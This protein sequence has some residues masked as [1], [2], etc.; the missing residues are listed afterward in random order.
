MKKTS[1]GVIVFF[2]VLIIL[3]ILFFMWVGL[4]SNAAILSYV[5]TTLAYFLCGALLLPRKDGNPVW[6]WTLNIISIAFFVVEFIASI[7]LGCLTDSI[8]IVGT[9]HLLIILGFILWAAPH[10]ASYFNSR[11]M[12]EQQEKNAAYVKNLSDKLRGIMLHIEDKETRKVV[13]KLT[14]TIWCSPRATNKEAQVKEAAV[15]E[16]VAEIEKGVA[17]ADWALV[18]S[19]A[20]SAI[21]TAKERNMLV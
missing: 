8:V 21:V 1:F 16:A 12:V 15:A 6:S 13:E 9:A 14:D 18:T 5:V 3:N 19:I 11:N 10:V 4:S 2:V 7:V 17:D 20:Q